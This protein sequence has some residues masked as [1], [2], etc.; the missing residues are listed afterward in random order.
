MASCAP[1]SRTGAVLPFLPDAPVHLVATARSVQVVGIDNCLQL[2]DAGFYHAPTTLSPDN[3]ICYLC[4]RAL[5]GWE[6]DD[7]PLAEHLKHSQD[8]GW[9]IL[10]DIARGSSNPAAI[11][12]PTSER[13]TE[14]RRS[15][16]RGWPHD[17]KRRWI[18]KSE[19]V[20]SRFAMVCLRVS[21]WNYLADTWQQ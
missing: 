8:C 10:M 5:D 11:E 4:E 19:K 21:L 7:D 13:I 9:A 2:A 18:C 6:E 15:T 1:D 3:T 12:D 14:A 20:G 16:F 17:G